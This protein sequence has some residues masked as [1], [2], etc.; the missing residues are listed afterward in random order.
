MYLFACNF[1]S[2]A[3]VTIDVHY[4]EDRIQSGNLS[5]SVRAIANYINKKE[6]LQELGVTARIISNYIF[7]NTTFEEV[8]LIEATSEYDTLLFSCTPKW[9]IMSP[10]DYT[11]DNVNNRVLF[12][13]YKYDANVL[14]SSILSDEES[15]LKYGTQILTP[16]LDFIGDNFYSYKSLIENYLDFYKE[17][18]NILTFEVDTKLQSMLPLEQVQVRLNASNIEK[19]KFLHT[20]KEADSYYYLNAFVIG[21]TKLDHGTYKLKVKEII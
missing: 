7:G 17:Q 11:V 21:A 4:G 6:E 2:S 5:P 9:L 16:Q 8:L 14:Y 13:P 19:Y 10:F 12:T 15:E 1:G 3:N 18:A 20:W